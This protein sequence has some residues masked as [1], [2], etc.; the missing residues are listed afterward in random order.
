MGK[1]TAHLHLKMDIFRARWAP[2]SEHLNLQM[3]NTVKLCCAENCQSILVIC[4]EE[5]QKRS[6]EH[7]LFA[8]VIQAQLFNLY[9]FLSLFLITGSS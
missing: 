9:L 5:Y 1:T 7:E 6:N 8:E 2:I 4:T 3:R